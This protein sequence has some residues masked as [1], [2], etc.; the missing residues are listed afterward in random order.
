MEYILYSV[1]VFP[2]VL[3]VLEAVKQDFSN[4]TLLLCFAHRLLGD[5]GQ[6]TISNINIS[7]GQTPVKDKLRV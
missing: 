3:I 6:Y 1:Q 5:I 2:Y 4:K 7:W